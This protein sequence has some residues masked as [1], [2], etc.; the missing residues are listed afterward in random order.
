MATATQ[1]AESEKSPAQALV[2]AN[3]AMLNTWVEAGYKVQT[4]SL[5]I[6]RVFIEAFTRQQQAGRKALEQIVDPSQPWYS[7]DRYSAALNVFTE[8]Q[9]ELLRVG[10]E[11][12][13]EL[14]AAAAEGRQTMETIVSQA[15][16]AGQAQQALLGSGFEAIRQYATSFG[17]Q[18]N[19]AAAA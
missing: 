15:R 14:N 18:M 12:I 13:D 11:Y 6:A 2:E 5:N 9:T 19:Q 3:A 17:G 7:P 10:R 16:E 1:A 4:R 8:N